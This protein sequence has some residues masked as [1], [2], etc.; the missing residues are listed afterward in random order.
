L[1]ELHPGAEHRCTHCNTTVVLANGDIPKA[2]H[3]RKEKILADIS[4][5]LNK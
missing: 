4:K 3:L 5:V 1:E 2:A